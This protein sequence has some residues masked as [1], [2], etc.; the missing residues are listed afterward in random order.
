M[1]STTR[2]SDFEIAIRR[3]L[4][5]NGSAG[6][7]VEFRI[8]SK[9]PRTGNFSPGVS[10]SSFER[11]EKALETS[12]SFAEQAPA[13]TTDYYFR[14]TEGR[15]EETGAW[16]VKKKV[17]SIDSPDGRVRA[18]A[19]YE[20]RHPPLVGTHPRDCSFFR[21]KIRRSWIW[22]AVP[23]RVDLT[24]VQS[25][26]DLDS[27]DYIY[28]IEIELLADDAVYSVPLDVLLTSGRGMAED[29]SRMCAAR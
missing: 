5:T 22:D 3:E 11:L 15:L 4:S 7:E 17:A 12:G 13:C 19:A 6:L 8:G 14:G 24:R 18:S 29:F 16:V 26:E 28:E 27:E 1:T 9:D 20:I 2:A 25:T 23:W 21:K 10:S